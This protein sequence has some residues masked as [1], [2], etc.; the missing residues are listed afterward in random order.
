MATPM[1][2]AV[3]VEPTLEMAVLEVLGAVALVLLRTERQPLDKLIL[4]LVAVEE[5]LLLVLADL[6]HHNEEVMR[7]SFADFWLG[8]E[9]DTLEQDLA[10][11]GFQVEDTH[12][13]KGDGSL[14]CLFY[15]AVRQSMDEKPD[16]A[17]AEV[18]AT[19]AMPG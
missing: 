18:T 17:E 1:L 15:R 9:T 6:D 12:S 5:E 3:A 4:V 11:A 19:G 8:F 2:V 7:S 13:G 14:A 16:R 10:D